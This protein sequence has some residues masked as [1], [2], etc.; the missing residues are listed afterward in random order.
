MTDMCN[1]AYKEAVYSRLR[2]ILLVYLSQ[3]TSPAPN[4]LY[5]PEDLLDALLGLCSRNQF[6][7]TCMRAMRRHG[8]RAMTGQRLLQLLGGI[9]RDDML[10]ISLG[11]LEESA[12]LLKKSGR[13]GGP[14]RLAVDEHL[15][16]R[17]DKKGIH[18]KSGKRKNGTNRFE[19]Y[20]TAQIVSHAHTLTL[21]AYPIADGERQ[22]DYLGGL[23]KNARR[24]GAI[25]EVLLL[26]RGFNSVDNIR[27]LDSQNVPYVMPLRGSK[28]LYNMMKE[29]DAG[30][31]EP[32]REYT[33][34]NKAGESS[35]STLVICL[36]KNPRKTGD[37]K[38]KYIAFLTNIQVD[39]PRKLLT[40][41]PKVYRQRWGIETGYRIIKQVRA[42]TKSPRASARL[43]LFHISLVYTNVWLLYRGMR[44]DDH[45]ELK[46]N[47]PMDDHADALWLYVTS[48]SRPP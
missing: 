32:I 30:T 21:G 27:E 28:K 20:I 31:G 9:P 4:A 25:I 12:A 1:D 40:Y 14:V 42:K 17:Y 46:T 11:I 45:T 43:F 41:I 15:L 13:L 7:A 35:T 24:L 44:V 22:A 16:E 6:V 26:D 39:N 19:G 34:T 2:G 33:M 36:K 29:V 18:H 3:I 5:G 8:V 38:D 23:I 47:I 10:E 37:V 48:S